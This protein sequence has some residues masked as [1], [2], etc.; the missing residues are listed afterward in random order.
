MRIAIVGKTQSGKS[1]APHRGL[2]HVPRHPWTGVILFDGKGCRLH[3][4]ANLPDVTCYG[5]DQFGP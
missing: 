4:Y 5:M 3:H 2:S 1:T